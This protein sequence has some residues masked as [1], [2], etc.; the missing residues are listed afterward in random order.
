ML[1]ETETALVDQMSEIT[2]ATRTDVIKNALA[3]Y[4]WFLRQAITERF[5]AA[6]A[7]PARPH[8]AAASVTG[9]GEGD[10]VKTFLLP[11]QAPKGQRLS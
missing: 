10:L 8:P 1:D 4:H 3:V 9:C 2:R 5:A 7:T 6:A 11:G